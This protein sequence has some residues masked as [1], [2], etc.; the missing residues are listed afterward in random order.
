MAKTAVASCIYQGKPCYFEILN[1]CNEDEIKKKYYQASIVCK[2][3]ERTRPE[4]AG[5]SW[6][7]SKRGI[8]LTFIY[9]T[10]PAAAKEYIE[11]EQ[12]GFSPSPKP[13]ETP[14]EVLRSVYRGSSDDG[15]D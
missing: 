3:L 8:K 1:A 6:Y 5:L 10:T 7:I 12:L 13:K 2:K 9:F 11:S 15:D 4:L 14:E